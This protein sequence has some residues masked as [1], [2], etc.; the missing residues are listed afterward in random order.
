MFQIITEE[1]YEQESDRAQAIYF[2]VDEQLVCSDVPVSMQKELL[3]YSKEHAPDW[4][5]DTLY[6]ILDINTLKAVMLT[7][8][9]IPFMI[10][11][12]TMAPDPQD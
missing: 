4:N 9:D 10:F 12:A 7:K 11:M 8:I 5:S 1:E 2:A 3:E 6:Y